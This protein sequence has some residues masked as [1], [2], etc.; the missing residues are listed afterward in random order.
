MLYL[1][2]A[3]DKMNT[4]LILNEYYDKMNYNKYIG[5]K[6]YN[7]FLDKLYN[8]YRN[9]IINNK[10]LQLLF[11][12]ENENLEKHNQKYIEEALKQE[13][14]YFDNMF[15]NIDD[16]IILDV[17]QRK[18]ILCDE[19]SSLIITGAGSGKT[20]TMAA[21]VKYLVERKHIDPSKIVVIS[22][23]NKATDELEDRIK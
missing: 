9:E 3:G 13:K 11:N 14:E 15:K 7:Q 8:K 22:Y 16:N 10:D 6:E 12:Q 2:K 18:A 1:N 19:D 23:T 4:K 20:T 21:K 17:E 5:I